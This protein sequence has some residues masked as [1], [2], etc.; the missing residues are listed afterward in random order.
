VGNLLDNAIDAVSSGPAGQWV[1]VEIRQDAASVEISVSDSGPGVP[2]EVAQE[3]FAHGFTT[4]AATAGE[5]GIGLA[6]T[7]LVCQRRGGEVRLA[8]TPE[9]GASFVARLGVAPVAEVVR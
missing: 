3:V 6:L 4:K 1:S 5:R 2:P 8:S 9:G 7:R